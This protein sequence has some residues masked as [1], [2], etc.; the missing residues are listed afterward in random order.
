MEKMVDLHSFSKDRL[1]M[2]ESQI[3]RRG[4]N[5]ERV[6]QAFRTIPRHL[7]VLEKY[8]TDAYTD[9]PL[10]IGKG[11]T[12]SQPYIVA[13]MTSNLKLTG[14]EKVLE[15]GT[16]S[17]YQTAILANLV[18][19][20]HSVERIP[21]LSDLAERNLRP[22]EMDNIYLH[23]GDGSLGWTD[24][25]PYDRILITAAAPEIPEI[26]LEQ[27]KVNGRLVSPVGGRWRQMLEVWVKEKNRIKKEQIL[28]VIFVPLRGAHGWQD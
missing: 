1:E 20:V 5:D 10:P 11:Q 24:A 27:L 12:I 2:V 13:L 16:G 18:K 21:Q 15:I 22:L 6:L 19:E 26:I 17:G 28:P 25:A 4:I 3:K 14:N 7:F 23:V 8:Q 9:H